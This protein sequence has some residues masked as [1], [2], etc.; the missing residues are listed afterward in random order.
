M[1]IEKLRPITM[2]DMEIGIAKL[3]NSKSEML[4][5]ITESVD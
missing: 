2:K 3:T 4:T 5:L 1:E